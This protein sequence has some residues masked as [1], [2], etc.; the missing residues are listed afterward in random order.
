MC[1]ECSG[2][3]VVVLK[4]IENS[5]ERQM[6][7]P[8]DNLHLHDEWAKKN[9]TRVFRKE[10]NLPGDSLPLGEYRSESRAWCASKGAQ[11]KSAVVSRKEKD[12]SWTG[13]DMSAFSIVLILL[14]LG[15][16]AAA[17]TDRPVFWLLVGPA[18]LAVGFTLTTFLR[19]GFGRQIFSKEKRTVGTTSDN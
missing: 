15:M 1:P 19:Q 7:Y 9:L 13:R 11:I 17:H 6:N 12:T 4:R 5:R 3:F 18:P 16:F 10:T 2:S 14:L 8:Y